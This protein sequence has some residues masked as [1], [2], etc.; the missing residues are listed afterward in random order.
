MKI[1]AK[2]EV[3]IRANTPYLNNDNKKGVLYP[4]FEIDVVEEVEGQEVD[5]NSKWY[6]DRN[7]DY[8]WSGGFE[9]QGKEENNIDP[10]EPNTSDNDLRQI[11]NLEDKLKKNDK[12][13]DIYVALVDSGVDFTLPEISMN[14]YSPGISGDTDLT[15]NYGHGTHLCGVI[16]AS[17]NSDQITGL[18]PEAKIYNCKITNNRTIQKKPLIDALQNIY[19]NSDWID[20]VNLSLNIDL[21]FTLPQDKDYYY[22]E[23]NPVLKKISETGV[24]IV[25]AAGDNFI[26]SG[27][28]ILVPGNSEYTIGVGTVENDSLQTYKTNGFHKMIDFVFLNKKIKSTLSMNNKIESGKRYG[29][30]GDCS[31]YTAVTTGIIANYLSLT[32]IPRKE[33]TENVGTYLKQISSK[34]DSI[35]KFENYMPYTP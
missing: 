30:M 35:E 4:G 2:K 33:R 14:S 29:Y 7:G 34:I 8:Y 28:Q 6:R 27:K 23:L 3:F 15:D 25:A 24:I 20:I 32:N 13:R 18:A 9:A 10:P 11:F 1:K 26:L 19:N 31:V 12:C 22:D 5:G 17:S 16:S 21:N